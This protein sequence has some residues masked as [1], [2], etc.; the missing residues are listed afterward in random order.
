MLL[1]CLL[2]IVSFPFLGVPFLYDNIYNNL[3]SI[4]NF[5]SKQKSFYF[6]FYTYNNYYV[7]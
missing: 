5:V 4:V 3:N 1:V 6:L 2:K 7:N